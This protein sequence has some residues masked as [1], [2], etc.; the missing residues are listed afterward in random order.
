MSLSCTGSRHI[1]TSFRFVLSSELAQSKGKKTSKQ[2]ADLEDKW[3]L[4]IRQIPIW[5]PIQLAYTPYIATLLPLVH[6]VNEPGAQYTHPELASLFF[7]SSLLP[8]IC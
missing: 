7:P 6:S 1:V 5:R 2:L 8:E 4:L 3:S